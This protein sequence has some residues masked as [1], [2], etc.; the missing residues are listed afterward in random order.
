MVG[1][2]CLEVNQVQSV[3]AHQGADKFYF[4][5][6]GSGRFRVGDEERQAE[7]GALVLAPAGISHGVVNNGN[8]RL[9]LLVAIAPPFK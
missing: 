4:V 7:A 8:V 3:H 5:L 9:S 2:N 1:L 6:E